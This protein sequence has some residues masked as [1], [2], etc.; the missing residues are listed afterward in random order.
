MEKPPRKLFSSGAFSEY[1]GDSKS[2]KP[3]RL[4]E[5]LDLEGFSL[6]DEEMD[7]DIQ[8]QSKPTI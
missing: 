7:P 6:V 5:N 8:S 2:S 1:R 4:K 3:E